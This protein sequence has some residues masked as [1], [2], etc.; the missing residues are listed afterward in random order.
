M[1]SSTWIF[2]QD[3]VEIVRTINPK[4]FL[5]IGVGFGKWGSLVRE[6]TDIWALNVK[7]ED[8]VTQIDGIEIYPSYILEHQKAIYNEIFI[9]DALQ[10]VTELPCYDMVMAGDVIE[11]QTKLAGY[12]LIS[13]L[14]QHTKKILVMSIPIGENWLEN[15]AGE[16]PYDSHLASWSWDDILSL[17]PDWGY[18][19]NV[20]D[21]RKMAFVCFLGDEAQGERDKCP[22]KLQILKRAVGSGF[23]KELYTEEYFTSKSKNGKQL[24]YGALGIK[25]WET[26]SIYSDIKRAIDSV[27]ID[28]KKILEIGFGRAESARYMLT[29][30]NIE[31]YYGVDF[32][33]AAYSLARKTLHECD[34]SKYHLEL[35]SALPFL[36]RKNFV[37]EYDVVY[38]LDC[39]EHIPQNEIPEILKLI[40]QALKPEGYLVVHTP[41]YPVDE[42]LIK[43]NYEYIQPTQSDLI[44]STAGMHCNKYTRNRLHREMSEAGFEIVDDLV[45]QKNGEQVMHIDKEIPCFSSLS[46]LELYLASNGIT[47]S[48]KQKEYLEC[49]LSIYKEIFVFEKFCS[50]KR[51]VEDFA[52]GCKM[53]IIYKY[54]S[55]IQ[56]DR[57]VKLI[58]DTCQIVILEADRP[59]FDYLKSLLTDCVSIGN[60]LSDDSSL[61]SGAKQW[62]YNHHKSREIPLIVS[63]YTID[64]PY[65]EEAKRFISDCEKLSLEY[66]VEPVQSKGNWE[67]NCSYKAMF[68][69]D[70]MR[71][72]HRPI[73]WVD[74]DAV[75][76]NR[77]EI[78]EGAACDFAVYKHNRWQFCSGTLFFNNTPLSLLLLEKWAEIS[79]SQPEMWD[80][81]TLDMAWEYIIKKFPLQTLWLPQSYV[82]IFDYP[83]EKKEGIP[84]IEHFQASRCYA[85][86]VSNGNEKIVQP[87]I[88]SEFI[89]V[90]SACRPRQS[91]LFFDK[92]AQIA[93][94]RSIYI[95]GAGS[96]GKKTLDSLKSVGITPKGF[97]D[98]DISRKGLTVEGICIYSP[99][100]LQGKKGNAYIIIGSSFYQEISQNLV[101]MDYVEN[102]DYC[103]NVSL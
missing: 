95:W 61:W 69:R 36:Q 6:Y 38:M 65:E 68:L 58:P 54:I 20:S 78:L 93:Q 35:S 22:S 63:Y 14:R 11:H 30:K 67:K 32:S 1:P 82:K 90:R 25:E 45:F 37:H 70:M 49:Q 59:I 80:Q 72:L 43:Q 50:D 26:G 66:K 18:L 89:R 103:R 4:S 75:I 96:G 46:Q 13:K 51:M 56:A 5:D 100:Q 74:I 41:F 27:C 76:H 3:F 62:N 15:A 79:N 91:E 52:A 102:D 40:H 71:K 85:K 83:W 55:D 48:Q 39:I 94:A 44:S 2:I 8:W 92:I 29:Q 60:Q 97:I 99:M 21:G 73:L 28:G 10:I 84:V 98:S 24:D 57:L 77:P 42:D 9:G 19:S 47:L 81:T 101:K 7:K 16:N 88:N 87:V 86:Q 64:T 34:Q 23:C 12:Q 33:P 31:F 17:E 53:L